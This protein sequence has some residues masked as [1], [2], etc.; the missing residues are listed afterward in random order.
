MALTRQHTA[1][2]ES[3]LQDQFGLQHDTFVIKETKES[4]HNF[5]YWI[6]LSCPPS[7]PLGPISPRPFTCPIPSDT[8]RLIFRLPRGAVSL[9][10]SVRIRNEVAFLSLGRNALYSIN[11]S[12]I[13][14]VFDWADGDGTEFGN[15]WILQEWKEGQTLSTKD[16]ESLDD[17]TQRFVLDQ[18]A[19]VLKAFQDFRLP[20]S[21]KGFGG[22]TFDEDGVM[23]ST[24]SVIPCGGPFSSYSNF[25]RG[26]LEWQLEATERSSHL[27]GWCEYPELRKRLQ[28]FF[29]DGLEAQLARVPEQ[30]QVMV[31]GDLG[32]LAIS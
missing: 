8:S 26:M 17:K 4:R 10:E 3:I 29:S 20:E 11:P 5:V 15:R 18:I 13:S 9:E 30:Q 7:E 23:T 25:L 27:R 2:A 12:L 14:Q 21:V 24:K 1:L 19:A 28:T 16:V 32:E 22:L 31:H 6:D